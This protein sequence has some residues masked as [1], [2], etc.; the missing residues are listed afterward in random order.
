MPSWAIVAVVAYVLGFFASAGQ[1]ERIK[2]W[3][4]WTTVIFWPF[5]G[6]A[7]LFA[8]LLALVGWM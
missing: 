8:M 2:G 4:G 5:F 7:C 1:A 3:E 6:A